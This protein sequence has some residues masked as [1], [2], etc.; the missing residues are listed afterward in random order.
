MDD[1][2]QLIRIEQRV[3][4]LFEKLQIMIVEAM[5]SLE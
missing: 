1:A 2:D 5:H 4:S 3:D